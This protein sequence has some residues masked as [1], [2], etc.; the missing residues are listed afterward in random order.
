MAYQVGK[1]IIKL[2]ELFLSTLILP[3]PYREEKIKPLK[4]AY[5]GLVFIKSWGGA[6]RLP[7][8]ATGIIIRLL[9]FRP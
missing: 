2:K 7:V 1:G 6:Q 4:E 8:L 9:L 3:I 5:M